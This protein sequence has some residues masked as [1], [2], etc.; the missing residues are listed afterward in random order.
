MGPTAVAKVGRTIIAESALYE[1]VED[2]VYVSHPS[3]TGARSR[4][5]ACLFADRPSSIQRAYIRRRQPAAT[6]AHARSAINYEFLKPSSTQKACPWKGEASFFDIEVDGVRIKDGAWCYPNP[7]A[8]F[9]DHRNYVA[10]CSFAPL[11]IAMR[12][13]PLKFRQ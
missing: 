5:Q 3:S 9:K 10:F 11:M 2:I 13:V 12:R 4:S 6:N 7:K 8:R 1:M